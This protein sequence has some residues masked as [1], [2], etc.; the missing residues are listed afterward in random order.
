[1]TS[2]VITTTTK[3]GLFA[4]HV[5]GVSSIELMPTEWEE[6]LSP[7]HRVAGSFIHLMVEE[8]TPAPRQLFGD[9]AWAAGQRR[10]TLGA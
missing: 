8:L 7:A 2:A 4:L 9:F 5:A 1:M 10:G 3:E 6:G